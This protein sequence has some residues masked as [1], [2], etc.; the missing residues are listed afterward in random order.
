MGSHNNETMYNIDKHG[1]T[2]LTTLGPYK[3]II[4]EAIDQ[5]WTFSHKYMNAESPAYDFP[6][7]NV[8]LD[9]HKARGKSKLHQY[10]SNVT[11]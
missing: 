1:R 10:T 7:I 11:K 8:L 9:I 2:P 3:S 6:P 5:L 4:G